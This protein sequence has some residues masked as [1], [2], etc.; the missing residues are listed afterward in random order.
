[1]SVAAAI[2][3][4][5]GWKEEGFGSR[6]MWHFWHFYN[7][8]AIANVEYARKRDVNVCCCKY[9]ENE[10]ADD[11]VRN[12]DDDAI[13]RLLT[14]SVMDVFGSFLSSLVVVSIFV[15]CAGRYSFNLNYFNLIP[16]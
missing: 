6:M 10:S 7:I 14:K 1:M 5:H 16:T 15:H 2:T 3:P 12:V 13:S 11:G 8:H 4:L 9:S